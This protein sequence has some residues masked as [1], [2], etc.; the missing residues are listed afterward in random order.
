MKGKNKVVV[1]PDMKEEKHD[2]KKKGEEDEGSFDAMKDLK[3]K[4]GDDPRSM[5]TLVNLMKNKLRAKGLNMS[6]KLNGELV[7][8]MYGSG[9]DKSNR[10]SGKEKQTRL[11]KWYCVRKFKQYLLVQGKEIMAS[12]KPTD[13]L[14]DA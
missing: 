13:S 2:D 1:N 10:N 4:E 3:P 9:G 7:D 5:P 11:K 14:V 6:F 8:E 12:Y